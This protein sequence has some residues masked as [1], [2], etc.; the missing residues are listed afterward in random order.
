M[1][2]ILFASFRRKKRIAAPGEEKKGD[3]QRTFR[4]VLWTL[5]LDQGRFALGTRGVWKSEMHDGVAERRCAERR[6][7]SDSRDEC[8]GRLKAEIF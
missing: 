8:D 2:S 5:P 1:R 6:D 4:S 3:D 7:L